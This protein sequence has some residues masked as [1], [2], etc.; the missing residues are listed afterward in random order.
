MSL[1]ERIS[2]IYR[3]P[4]HRRDLDYTKLITPEAKRGVF[5]LLNQTPYSPGFVNQWLREVE[6]D[7]VLLYQDFIPYCRD[8]HSYYGHDAIAVFWEY[9][10]KSSTKSVA[11]LDFLECAF[12]N[13][14]SPKKNDLIRSINLVLE[15]NGC[16][17]RL[18]E[19]V[20]PERTVDG[21]VQSTRVK[22]YPYIYLAQE[23]IVDDYALK[24]VL[25][26]F[27][28]P[29]FDKPNKSFSNA[30]KRHKDGDYSGCITSCATAV[31]E[32][33]GVISTRKGWNI[34]YGGVGKSVQS[35]LRQS[36]FPPKLKIL[37]DFIAERRNNVGDAHGSDH[38]GATEADARF[39]IGLS[40]AFIV[41]LASERQ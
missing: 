5:L 23:P 39:L 7:F 15:N 21:T 16:P 31:E 6:K 1:F 19:F 9:F 4:S 29:E 33:I 34:G 10:E 32:S 14:A 28:D 11:F 25:R 26:L 24:P 38:D 40:A 27:A 22:T 17:Y 20:W 30:L 18:S 35:F 2:A 41:F 8:D 3:S 12:M 13:Q 37:G 36:K